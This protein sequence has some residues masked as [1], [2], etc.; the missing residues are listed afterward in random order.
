[1]KKKPK[2]KRIPKWVSLDSVMEE[3]D[4]EFERLKLRKKAGG[5]HGSAP[6]GPS[7]EPDEGPEDVE[8]VDSTPPNFRKRVAMPNYHNAVSEM[9]KVLRAKAEQ[10]TSEA[11]EDSHLAGC[12]SSRVDSKT[13]EKL[14]KK[15]HN[16]LLKQGVFLFRHER[17]DTSGKDQLGL[18]PTDNWREVLLAMQ[19]YGGNCDLMPKDIVKWLKDLREEHPFRL[20]GA[21]H[22]WCE[23]EFLQPIKN[24]PQLAKK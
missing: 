20:T 9:A 16:R 3:L 11:E 22:D 2:P 6:A 17:G 4:A 13:S 12:M 15:H 10:L 8:E 19:T 5:K 7:P 21:A 1:M 14:V 18:L 23:G 24:S